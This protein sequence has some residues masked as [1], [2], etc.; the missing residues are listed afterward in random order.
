MYYY[1]SKTKRTESTK[2][3]PEEG[4]FINMSAEIKFVAKK[5]LFYDSF[6][7]RIEG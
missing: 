7:F 5:S 2:S 4:L 6:L 3:M 1:N